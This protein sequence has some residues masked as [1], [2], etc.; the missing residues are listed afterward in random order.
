MDGTD[1]P[2]KKT[3]CGGSAHPVF[4]GNSR[5]LLLRAFPLALAVRLDILAV[6]G[7]VRIDPHA[8]LPFLA[9]VNLEGVAGLHFWGGR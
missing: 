6:F 9:A 1:S 5:I 8:V 3:G 4:A 2:Q 7:F